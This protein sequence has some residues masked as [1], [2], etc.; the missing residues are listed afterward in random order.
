MEVRDFT[1][2]TSLKNFN[3][4]YHT[5]NIVFMYKKTRLGEVTFL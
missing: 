5:D 3:S 1:S 4:V 2:F